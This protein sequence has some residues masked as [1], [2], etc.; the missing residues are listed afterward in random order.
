M[1]EEVCQ[2]AVGGLADRQRKHPLLQYLAVCK[3]GT[4]RSRRDC[5]WWKGKRL[6][7]PLSTKATLFRIGKNLDAGT[8]NPKQWD[9]CISLEMYGY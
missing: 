9:P 7:A 2:L 4:F 5:E 1:R 8:L 6:F 3:V